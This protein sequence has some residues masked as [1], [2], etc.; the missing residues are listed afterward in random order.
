MAAWSDGLP[1]IRYLCFLTS[2]LSQYEDDQTFFSR[3]IRKE[4]VLNSEYTYFCL[5]SAFGRC[6]IFFFGVRYRA[7]P[8]ER[9]NTKVE[10]PLTRPFKK[11]WL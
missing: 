7:S 3:A 9:V 6:A 10:S 11:G 5:T 1:W 4:Q 8:N 2:L